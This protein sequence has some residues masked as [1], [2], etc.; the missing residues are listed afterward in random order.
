MPSLIYIADPMCAWC[1]GFGPE[2]DTLLA[3]LPGLRLDIVLGGL[4]PYRRDALD[5]AARDALIPQ[6]RKVQEASGLQ[7]T[8]ACLQREGFVYDTE[9]ACRAVATARSF[10]SS[11]QL[12]MLKAI[13]HAFFS[14]G[15]DV[16]RGD[17][18]AELGAAVLK[19]SGSDIGAP[20]FFE[21][22]SQVESIDATAADF[23]QA[24]RW[25]VT[26]FPTLVLERDGQLDLVTSGFMRT[27]ELVDRMQAIVDASA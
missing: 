22:W 1:Y 26:G 15:V 5:E 20:A 10:A 13:Q 19:Q 4:D 2:L 16:T 23:E 24:R 7:L 6:W 8:E 21:K 14:D 9:P 18:L 25:G 27:H 11:S 17:A 3:G 12:G